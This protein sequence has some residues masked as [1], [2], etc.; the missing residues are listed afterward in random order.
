VGWFAFG[1]QDVDV[2]EAVFHTVILW[3]AFVAAQL[4]RG[5]PSLAAGVPSRSS[6]RQR[7]AKA[8][9]GDWHSF[10]PYPQLITPIVT[11]FDGPTLPFVGT[12]ERL[13]RL[14]A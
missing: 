9:R 6:P 2:E 14:C 8:G 4:R 1:T 10:E 13:L 5:Q 3:P 7:R 11:V 12:A